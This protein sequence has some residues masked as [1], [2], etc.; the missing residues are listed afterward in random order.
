ME[1]CRLEDTTIRAAGAQRDRIE[2]RPR[3]VRKADLAS[4]S[5]KY[6]AGRN[7]NQESVSRCRPG[8]GPWQRSSDGERD[9]GRNTKPL[10]QDLRHEMTDAIGLTGFEPATS[11]PPVQRHL[12]DT[13]VLR[14]KWLHALSQIALVLM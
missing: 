9:L 1:R 8:V 4:C 2:Q 6:G 13:R 11:A 7:D 5:H 14:G 10:R 3:R 12:R